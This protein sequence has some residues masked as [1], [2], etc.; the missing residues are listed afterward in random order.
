MSV[1]PKL[2]FDLGIW[3]IALVYLSD[4]KRF[5]SRPLVFILMLIVLSPIAVA[6][7]LFGQ[8]WDRRRP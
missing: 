4:R 6:S 5:E 2:L 3:V 7:V 8:E 1:S